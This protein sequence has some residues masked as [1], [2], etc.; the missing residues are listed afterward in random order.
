MMKGRSKKPLK[1]SY[2]FGRG[3]KESE[4][5]VSKNGNVFEIGEAIYN[6]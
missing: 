1:K 2:G 5:D 6:N 3:K 4:Q